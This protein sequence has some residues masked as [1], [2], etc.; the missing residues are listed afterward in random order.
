MTSVA[1]AT[2]KY[3]CVQGIGLTDAL[4]FEEDTFKSSQISYHSI[5]VGI[6]CLCSYL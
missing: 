1:T 5:Q 2:P 6:H 3:L 4:R